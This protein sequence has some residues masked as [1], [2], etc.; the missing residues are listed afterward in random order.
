MLIKMYTHRNRG[1]SQRSSTCV[2][3]SST[4]KQILY[5]TIGPNVISQTFRG[6]TLILQND[7]QRPTGVGLSSQTLSQLVLTTNKQIIS[8]SPIWIS[9]YV[10]ESVSVLVVVSA[11][12][13]VDW[14]RRVSVLEYSLPMFFLRTQNYSTCLLYTSPSPRDRG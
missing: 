9:R 7:Q 11:S 1:K 6:S 10:L 12:I 13:S 3:S 14:F 8:S 5:N 4:P 2:S